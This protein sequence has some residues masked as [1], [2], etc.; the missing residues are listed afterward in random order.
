MPKAAKPTFAAKQVCAA[1]GVS[2]GTLNSWAH[3]GYF[4]Q[5]DAGPTTPGKARKFSFDDL[6][7]LLIRSQVADFDPSAKAWSWSKLCVEYMKSSSPSQI[8]FLFYAD[9][10]V[11]IRLDDQEVGTGKVTLRLTIYPQTLEAEL[12]QRLAAADD[13]KVSAMSR[14]RS[15]AKRAPNRAPTVGTHKTVRQEP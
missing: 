11:E 12:R 9:G 4:R 5:F 10:R 13:L 2:H 14:P 6:L 15:A 8:N 1:L 7:I 3:A